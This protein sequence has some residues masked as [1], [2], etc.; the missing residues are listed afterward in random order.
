MITPD[1]VVK[2][3]HVGYWGE[4]EMT[5]FDR[6]WGV[7]KE[8]RFDRGWPNV[9]AGGGYDMKT[10]DV[11]ANLSSITQDFRADGRFRSDEELMDRINRILGH[12]TAHQA[13]SPPYSRDLWDAVS[14][15]GLPDDI[16]DEERARRQAKVDNDWERF[17]EYG[18]WSV[19]PGIDEDKKWE[20]LRLYGIKP[21]GDDS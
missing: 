6:A 18:A 15:R 13:L 19:T 2:N 7:V 21:K 1:W 17:Q 8:F 10:G 4:H 20:M 14:A 3:H 12:E 9:L 5:A 11:F 16:S